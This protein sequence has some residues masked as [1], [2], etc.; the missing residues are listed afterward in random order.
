MIKV[1]NDKEGKVLS[2]VRQKD[3]NKVFAVFNFSAETQEVSFQEELFTGVYT[4]FKTVDRAV[5]N[6]DLKLEMEPWS[7]LIY[8]R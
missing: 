5:L 8:Y 3:E 7:Y 2:F 6:Q 4:E 1:P